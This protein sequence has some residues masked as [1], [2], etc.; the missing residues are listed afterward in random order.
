MDCNSRFVARNWL[1]NIKNTNRKRMIDVKKVFPKIENGF[2]AVDTSLKNGNDLIEAIHI[3][4]ALLDTPK[5]QRI[6]KKKM[7]DF[8]SK[9]EVVE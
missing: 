8:I 3:M 2:D 6:H 1:F 4:Q 9:F 7:K 5:E